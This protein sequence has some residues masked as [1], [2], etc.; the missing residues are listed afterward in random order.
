MSR[1]SGNDGAMWG[2]RRNYDGY[3]EVEG[4]CL[5]TVYQKSL[6]DRTT[7]CTQLVPLTSAGRGS[8]VGAVT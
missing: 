8:F 5:I 7:P 2:I 4:C 1:L 3:G 6:D